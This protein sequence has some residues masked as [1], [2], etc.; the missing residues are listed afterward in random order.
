MSQEDQIQL[1][2]LAVCA[3]TEKLDEL[4]GECLDAEGKPKAPDRKTLARMRGYLPPQYR[5]AYKESRK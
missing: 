1:L 2:K 3:L 5:N 4:I